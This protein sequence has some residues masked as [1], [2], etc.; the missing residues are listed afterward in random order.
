MRLLL[1]GG[2]G[3][4]GAHVACELLETGHEVVVLDDL[5]SGYA[6]AL[7]R[8]EGLTGRSCPLIVGDVGDASAVAHALKGVSA[9]VHLAAY[10]L[11][12]E[13]MR[14]PER[15]FRNN[16][17]GMAV[18]LEGMRHA[19]VGRFV[20]SSSAAVYGEQAVMPIAEGATLCPT[21]PYGYVKAQG[22]EMLDWMARLCGWSVVS[23][24]YFN[25]VGAHPSARIGQPP[26][27]GN[28]LIPRVLR[29]AAGLAPP[30]TI[31]GS[32]YDTPDG[33]C[34]RDY[35]HITD[36]ARAHVAALGVLSR[37]G[38]RRFNVG[39]GVAHSVR[40]VVVACARA[41]GREVP[42][43]VGERRPGD[44]PCAVADARRLHE[45][46]GFSAELGLDA[47]VSSAWRWQAENP[48]GYGA[49]ARP[50]GA[51]GGG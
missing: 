49:P 4:I 19:G 11:V 42:H 2:A 43:A 14:A 7:A 50:G 44:I 17:G 26:G 47:M 46:V 38:H 24:R 25:P 18:L 16:L 40:E 6:E 32:D 12:D 1:T 29:A 13:S 51:C 27:E 48:E 28:G 21:S 36:L 31:F 34:L 30:I 41:S 20:Y 39:T 23:L 33:T 3:Y 10:K 35:V 45:A 15:Y 8:V 37:P 22:E 5:S 9:V